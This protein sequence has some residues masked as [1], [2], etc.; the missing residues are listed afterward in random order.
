VPYF[1]I[2][3]TGVPIDH[4]APEDIARHI[5]RVC[6]DLPVAGEMVE[7]ARRRSTADPLTAVAAHDEEIGDR[8]SIEGIVETAVM[9]DEREAGQPAVDTYQEWVVIGR[10]PIAVEPA[11][12][13]AP[14][15]IHVSVIEFAEVVVVELHQV[16]ERR[17][18]GSSGWEQR[19]LHA[20]LASL[21]RRD[22]FGATCYHAWQAHA[23]RRSIVIRPSGRAIL[24]DV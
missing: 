17:L 23:I 22:T 2:A 18:I 21:C 5:L 19:N 1:R 24:P 8:M 14:L 12:V 9:I 15:L 20:Y 4:A 7:Q 3:P 6:G 10:S 16:G 11:I 13:E